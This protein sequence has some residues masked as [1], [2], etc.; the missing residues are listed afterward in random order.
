MILRTIKCGFDIGN[1]WRTIGIVLRLAALF[2]DHT[3]GLTSVVELVYYLL[4]IQICDGG[5]VVLRIVK[6]VLCIAGCLS[7]E[8]LCGYTPPT[9]VLETNTFTAALYIVEIAGEPAAVV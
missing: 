2:V 5:S 4:V 3:Y 1:T 9:V 7:E 8:K 6:G